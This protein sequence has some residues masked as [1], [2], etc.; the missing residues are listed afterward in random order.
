MELKVIEGSRQ[1]FDA[2]SMFSHAPRTLWQRWIDVAEDHRV[3]LACR[4]LLIDNTILFESGIGAFFSPKMRER[5]GVVEEEHKLLKEL[6]SNQVEHIILSHL[7]FDHAGGLLSKYEEG[8]PLQLLFPNAKFWIS[9]RALERAKNPHVRDRAS[10]IPELAPLLE[11]SGRLKIIE[12]SGVFPFHP[13]ISFRESQGHTPG[14]LIVR[15]ENTYL[16]TD[17][18]PGVPWVNLPITTSFDRFPELSI[19]EKK[20]LLEEVVENDGT[21]FLTHDPKHPFC[22]VIKEGEKFKGAI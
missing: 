16:P 17:L 6:D 20:N 19:D 14:M 12:G 21:L 4:S 11:A 10:F 1:W 5:Y 18:I 2:G 8:K 15:A 3:L 22:K 7:H 13:K 9:R